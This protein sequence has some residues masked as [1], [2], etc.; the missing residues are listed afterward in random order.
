MVPHL[1]VRMY[2][3]HGPH[4]IAYDPAPSVDRLPTD[5]RPTVWPSTGDAAGCDG[6]KR[7]CWLARSDR[8]RRG[9]QSDSLH[10]VQIEQ[11]IDFLFVV[12]RTD[13]VCGIAEGAIE[14]D[15]RRC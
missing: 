6:L 11:D 4:Q 3:V 13:G 1:Y 14:Y 2:L 10:A 5:C 12:R 7:T 15:V 9:S 8:S